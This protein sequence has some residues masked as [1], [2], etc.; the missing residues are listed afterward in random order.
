MFLIASFSF[1]RFNVDWPYYLSEI[2]CSGPSKVRNCG[3]NNWDLVNLFQ[4]TF[5]ESLQV[6]DYGIRYTSAPFA[7]LVGSIAKSSDSLTVVVTKVHILKALLAAYF[8]SLTLYFSQRFRETRILAMELLIC[9]FA[10]PYTLFMTASVYPASIA[11][12][13]LL[14]CLIILRIVEQTHLPVRTLLFLSGNLLIAA[15]VIVTNRFETTVFMG[16]AV[17]IF[18]V[19]NWRRRR[20]LRGMFVISVPIL[21]AL[22]YSVVQNAILRRWI[23]R[24]IRGEAKILEPETAESSSAVGLL[25]DAGL[26]ITAPVTFFDNSS[27]NLLSAVEQLS[28]S[29]D[30]VDFIIL[31]VCWLP[32]T[33]LLA[34]KVTR[35]LPPLFSLFRG[36]LSFRE[37]NLT[38][39]SPWHWS[40]SF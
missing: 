27:R 17:A 29:P 1:H 18:V 34:W 25:G 22:A 9:A 26:S 33:S 28:S 4:S 10:F 20:E 39:W 13:A 16:L 2:V 8:I 36:S 5:A 24:T 35:L 19:S 12:V 40:C 21:L 38:N 32:L 15:S 30:Y 3:P 31:V 11:S 37:Y 23:T 6:F 7:N 14:P